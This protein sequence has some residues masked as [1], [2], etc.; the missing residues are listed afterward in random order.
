MLVGDFMDAFAGYNET[1]NERLKAI[2]E[3]IRNATVLIWN[4]QVIEES[5]KMPEELWPFSWD[6][7]TGRE[8]E[9]ISTEEKKR[10]QDAQE[11][12]LLSHF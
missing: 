3:L 6:K 9:I 8:R 7:S 5:R 12:F 11:E 4:T 10:R 1:E 2:A